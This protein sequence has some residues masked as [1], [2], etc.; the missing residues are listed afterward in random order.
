MMLA[1]GASDGVK[2]AAVVMV[3]MMMGFRFSS[4]NSIF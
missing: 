2:V 4:E 3:V 1:M